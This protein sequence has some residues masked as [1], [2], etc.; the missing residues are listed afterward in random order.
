MSKAEGRQ[1]D[2]SQDFSNR[3]VELR[4]ANKEKRSPKQRVA[5]KEWASKPMS[6]AA[7]ERADAKQRTSSR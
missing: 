1:A 6:K 3:I 5:A 7:N 4:A 2:G